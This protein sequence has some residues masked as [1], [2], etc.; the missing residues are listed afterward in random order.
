MIYNCSAFFIAIA[1]AGK[2]SQDMSYGHY[3]NCQE[4]DIINLFTVL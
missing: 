2:A 3:S 1:I 4:Y